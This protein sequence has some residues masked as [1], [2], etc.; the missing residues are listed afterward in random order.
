M[1]ISN[2]I[3]LDVKLLIEPEVGV[4]QH[5]QLQP[6]HARLIRRI[7]HQ[8]RPKI[9]YYLKKKR[10]KKSRVR[11]FVIVAL[12]KMQMAER[13]RLTSVRDAQCARGAARADRLRRPIRVRCLATEK[14]FRA[15]DGQ[16]AECRRWSQHRS[17]A[18]TVCE[19]DL[20]KKWRNAKKKNGERTYV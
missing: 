9:R 7:E 18:A 8:R 14:R 10:G 17:S 5:Q 12:H 3:D 4:V 13:F 15:T 16:S 11:N 19:L 1:I 20:K 2:D 6:M